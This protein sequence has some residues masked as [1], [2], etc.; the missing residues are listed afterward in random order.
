M[1]AQKAIAGTFSRIFRSV[2]VVRRT[3]A[4]LLARGARALSLATRSEVD[5][6]T[7]RA[8]LALGR[9]RRRRDDAEDDS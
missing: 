3:R 1:D 5:A 2:F 6:L 4:R 9:A 8:D 7:A